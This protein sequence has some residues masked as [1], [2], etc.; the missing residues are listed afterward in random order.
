MRQLL[1]I[2]DSSKNMIVTRSVMKRKEIVCDFLTRL[3][4]EQN[5]KQKF[6]TMKES[7]KL[8][9]IIKVNKLGY[10]YLKFPKLIELH[11]FLFQCEP[12][13][14]HNALN[15]ILIC[16]RCF[17]KLKYDYDILDKNTTIKNMIE[18]LL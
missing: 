1:K 11:Q 5:P 12:R 15:D 9:R 2:K 14:L 10:N 6:C 4:D 3:I 18:P 13:N 17:C 8:C 7:I 16:L